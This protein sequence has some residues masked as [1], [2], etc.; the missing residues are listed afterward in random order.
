[1]LEVRRCLASGAVAGVEWNEEYG[2][3]RYRIDALDVD[4]DECFL[5]DLESRNGTYLIVDKQLLPFTMAL[6]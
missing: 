5:T 2:R 6:T 1:M 4:G 3:W